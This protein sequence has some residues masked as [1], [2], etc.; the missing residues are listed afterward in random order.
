MP[1]NDKRR[2]LIKYATELLNDASRIICK[3]LDEEQDCLDNMPDNLQD[4]NRCIKMED[5][6]DYLQDANDS[7]DKAIDSIN[8]AAG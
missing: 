3:A 8:M 6:I 7:I 4:T 2:T 5:A 1:L